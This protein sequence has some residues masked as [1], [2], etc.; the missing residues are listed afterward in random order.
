ME[1]LRFISF[2]SGSSGNAYYIGTLLQ[3]IMIDAGVSPRSL[4]K[5]MSA[6]GLSLQAVLGV[7]VTHDHIDHISYVGSYG[8][9]LGLPVYATEQ[10]HRGI[11]YNSSVKD[12][13]GASKRVFGKGA[14]FHLG[15]FTLTAFDIPHDGSDNVGYVVEYNGKTLVIATDLGHIPESLANYVASANYLVLESNYD[16]FMLDSG[17][18]PYQLKKRIRHDRGHL[19]NHIAAKFVA[20]HYHPK[21]SHLFLCHLSQTNNRPE[22]ALKA[23][24]EALANRGIK[25]GV[26]IEVHC[27]PRTKPSECFLL[28]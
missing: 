22:L 13:P 3:G 28:G 23:V 9:K 16:D 7:C 5:R 18:Y 21:L 15:P 25:A 10:V 17:P 1:E 8:E 12:K 20:E 2:A 27:L 24:S 14:P 6:V 4:K 11:V 26:D 19:S